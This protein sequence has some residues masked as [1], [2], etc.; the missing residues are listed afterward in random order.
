MYFRVKYDDSSPQLDIRLTNIVVDTADARNTGLG[1]ASFVEECQ[2]PTGTYFFDHLY[3]LLWNNNKILFI[4]LFI[5]FVFK[6]IPVYL[7][8][9]AHLVI[10]GETV[11]RGLDSVTETNRRVLQDTTAI[12]QETS[13]A[14][15]VLV[16]L[17]IRRTSKN[18]NQIKFI[19]CYWLIALIRIRFRNLRKL[20]NK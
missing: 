8:S 10:W 5:T 11:D 13:L 14:R 7:A 15:F 1:S 16:H 19:P 20:K 3:Y 6:D 12:P 4:L 18:A 9:T 17:P 2:C